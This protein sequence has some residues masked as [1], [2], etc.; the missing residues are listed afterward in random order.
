MMKKCSKCGEMKLLD[1]FH[2]QKGGKYG[3][4]G[5]CKECNCQRNKIYRNT[6]HEERIKYSRNYD[7][8][9]KKERAERDMKNYQNH[10]EEKKRYSKNYYQ[11]H[12]DEIRQ[13][14][15][16]IS[17]YENK[18]CS[19]YLGVVIAER[20]VRHLFNDVEVM[21]YGNTGFDIICN[22]G[23]KIDVKSA[24]VTLD[25]SHSHWLFNTNYNTIADFFI[26]VAFDNLTDLNPLH[27]W[28]IPGHIFNKQGSAQ[29]RSSTI[30]KWDKW[31][32][33]INDAQLCC[34][35]MKQEN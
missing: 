7:Q 11:E 29:I 17:M 6:H 5:E 12:K 25:R 4:R 23:K 22:K 24:T 2:K 34:N 32:R 10:K 21:P 26:L 1:E 28:M 30:H 31:K 20:L 8:E 16:Q 14:I 15:G 9:H 18:S 35:E 27:L 19:L 3:V 33:D 13:K